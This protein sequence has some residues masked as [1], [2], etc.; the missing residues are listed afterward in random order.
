MRKQKKL[1][2]KIFIAAF[3]IGVSFGLGGDSSSVY[4]DERLDERLADFLNQFDKEKAERKKQREAFYQYS[5]RR[6]WEKAYRADNKR[7]QQNNPWR[8][9]LK[10]TFRDGLTRTQ[11]VKYDAA[12]KA[13]DCQTIAR[14]SKNGFLQLYPFLEEAFKRSDIILFFEKNIV[15]IHTRDFRYCRVW[16]KLH[17]TLD[18]IKRYKISAKPVWIEFHEEKRSAYPPKTLREEQIYDRCKALTEIL[19]L[20]LN[21]KIYMPAIQDILNFTK[22][23]ALMSLPTD[24][25]YH[26]LTLFQQKEALPPAME[27]RY[28]RLSRQ[29]T[30]EQKIIIKT[31]IQTDLKPLLWYTFFS[32]TCNSTDIYR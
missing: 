1:K 2:N 3:I 28:D 24:M 11:K 14:L 26:F 30:D 31:R 15:E 18:N 16:K 13:L 12:L 9:Y 7:L 21:R 5:S 4:A 17:R 32:A 25:E 23:P 6:K 22:Q 8:P 10:R 29:L 27:K 19:Y 20:A